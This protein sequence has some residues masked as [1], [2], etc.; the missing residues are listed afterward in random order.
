MRKKIKEIF[1][2]GL[3]DENP[4]FRL[5]LGTCPTLAV[6]TQAMNGI[7][8]G[9]AV[10]FILIGSNVV[11]SLLRKFIP[12]KVR[13]PAFIVVICMFVTTIQLFMQAFLPAL[14]KSLGIFLPL[15]VVNCIILARAE[16]FA[17]KNRVLY[18]AVD[19]LGM[20]LGFTCAIT[21]IG[22]IR[23]LLGNGTLFGARIFMDGYEP[24]LIFAL[25]PGGF[26]VFGLLLGLV[27]FITAKDK[28][29]KAAEDAAA[30]EET[31]AEEAEAAETGT[32]LAET[33]TE[34]T[35]ETEEAEADT[36]ETGTGT[37]QGREIYAEETE[38]A[39]K[40]E[41]AAKTEKTQKDIPAETAKGEA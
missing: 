6:T 17:S 22:A 40:A 31:D 37:A 5:V 10:T 9:L 14:Y 29:R 15:I 13:I 32:G 34:E 11:I 12:E 2:N 18:A 7:G 3:I 33:Y 26:I 35:A 28:E 38:E 23:E 1:M 41:E 8:M 4:T 25:A 20:G 39:E 16:A 24:M 19:G 27:N 21:L 30:E 36:G